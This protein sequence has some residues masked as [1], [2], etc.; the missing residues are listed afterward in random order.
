MERMQTV[1]KTRAS[2]ERSL[3]AVARRL[4][5]TKRDL[6]VKRAGD[7]GGFIIVRY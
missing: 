7:L 1:Y 4:G 2:A 5:V 3:W 6:K